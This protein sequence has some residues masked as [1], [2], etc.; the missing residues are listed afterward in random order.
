MFDELSQRF[1]DAVKSLRG[2]DTITEGNVDGALKQVRRALLEADV[3]LEVIKGF[4]ADVRQKAIGAEVVRG[5]SPDQQFIQ[6]VHQ[7]LVEVMGGANAPLTRAET[8]P[9]VI[10]MA[11]LQGA[12]KTTATAKLGLHLKEQGRRALLVAADV[13][14]PAAIDQLQTLGNQIGV[15][16][17]SLGADAKP[18]DIAAAGVAKARAEGFDTVLVDTAGRLRSM[19]R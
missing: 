3:S 17:F 13:Y 6:L 10:L 15:E 8:A 16:V 14:R 1:E 18:E 7:A 19:P 5:V 4:I 11:G 9:T 2:Q 12:G